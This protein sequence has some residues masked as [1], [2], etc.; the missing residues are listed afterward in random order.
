MAQSSRNAQGGRLGGNISRFDRSSFLSF[1]A[2]GTISILRIYQHSSLRPKGGREKIPVKKREMSND[3]LEAK[4]NKELLILL[5]YRLGKLEDK[6]GSI[7]G[8]L[9]SKASL[10]DM[11]ELEK[12]VEDLWDWKNRVIGFAIASGALSGTIGGVL[13]NL[14]TKFGG[15]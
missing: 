2:A 1:G 15:L 11:D 14:L 3:N 10:N 7:C 13:A 6:V 12:K 5:N 4:T 8:N 9:E